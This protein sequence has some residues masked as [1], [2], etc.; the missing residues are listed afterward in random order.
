MWLMFNTHRRRRRD[1]DA[2]QL[3]SWVASASAVCIGHK[4]VFV[5]SV[6]A[7]HRTI[8]PLNYQ[9]NQRS[10]S[11]SVVVDD[12]DDDESESYV[13]PL[14]QLETV[15]SVLVIRSD[16]QFSFQ[17]TT[18]RGCKLAAAYRCWKTKFQVDGPA[19][20]K[21]RGPYRSVLVAGTARSPRAAERIVATTSVI[22]ESTSFHSLNFWRELA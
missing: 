18:I 13:R 11:R 3:D 20:A 5:S 14:L 21:L 22:S 4:C 9:H 6:S 7:I 1:A 2:T 17:I 12:D 8:K 15:T 19:T 10:S 16:K